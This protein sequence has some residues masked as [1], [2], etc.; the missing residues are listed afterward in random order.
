MKPIWTHNRENRDWHW[1]RRRKERDAII[2]LIQNEGDGHY[3]FGEELNDKLCESD[4]A[5]HSICEDGFLVKCIHLKDITK[6]Y[7]YLREAGLIGTKTSRVVDIAK[8]DRV[9]R[10]PTGA[11]ER[12]YID[13]R[14]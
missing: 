7:A 4:I 11:Y 10:V 1:L 9:P 12:M 8:L 13:G 5:E 3:D 2:S 6:A 14:Y